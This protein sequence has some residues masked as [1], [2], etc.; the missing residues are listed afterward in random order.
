M[1]WVSREGRGLPFFAAVA[2]GAATLANI[3]S[4]ACRVKFENA[5]KHKLYPK[6]HH[7]NFSW[8]LTAAYEMSP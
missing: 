5:A 1:F 8:Q 4:R 2:V 6:L 7:D 3:C